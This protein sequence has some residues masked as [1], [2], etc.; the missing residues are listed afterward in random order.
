MTSSSTDP[1]GNAS[2]E[3]ARLLDALG[4]WLGARAGP[5]THGWGDH[6]ATGAAECRLCPLC[7]LIALARETSPELAGHLDDA[8]RSV[9]SALRLVG[10]HLSTGAEGERRH[11]GFETIVIN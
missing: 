6:L 8:L 9:S 10:D 4:Q 7:R 2:Q 1:L 11:S 3:A 5:E